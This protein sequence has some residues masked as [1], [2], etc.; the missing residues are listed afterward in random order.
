MSWVGRDL[1]DHESYNP[2]PFPP[3]TGPPHLILDQDAQGPI[4]P[5]LEHLQGWS[6]H[7][8]SGQ[9]VPAPHRSLGKKLPHDIQLKSSLVNLKP[10][11][12]VLLLSILVIPRAPHSWTK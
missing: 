12:L 5:S 2:P 3:T 4:Q 10:F 8:L 6:I 11:L 9:P 1:E 7:N